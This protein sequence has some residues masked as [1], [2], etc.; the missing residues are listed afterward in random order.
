MNRSDDISESAWAF[1]LREWWIET[2]TAEFPGQQSA[3]VS[4]ADRTLDGYHDLD[5]VSR[6]ARA[7]DAFA[8]P[9]REALEFY[10]ERG[11]K[12]YP[13]A[14]ETLAKFVVVADSGTK[15][16]ATLSALTQEES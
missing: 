6:L 5:D 15:A 4:L 1:A 2:F 9:L 3:D 13:L 16:R 12:R 14:V 7:A 8:K 10:G 11:L